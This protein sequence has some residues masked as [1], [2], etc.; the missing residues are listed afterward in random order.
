MRR[1][2]KS[3]WLDISVSFVGR[4]HS[5]RFLRLST[6]PLERSGRTFNYSSRTRRAH[7]FCHFHWFRFVPVRWWL[8]IVSLSSSDEGEHRFISGSHDQTIRIWKYNQNKN[9]AQTLFICQGHQAT[10]ETLA[11]QNNFFA[12]GSFDKTIKLWSL[13]SSSYR[14]KIFIEFLFFF[15]KKKIS[16]VK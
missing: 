2:V 7:S 9:E 8:I 3:W 6:L 4:Y 15:L 11:L 10:V 12:S 13:G 16:R 5:S 1:F 14:N